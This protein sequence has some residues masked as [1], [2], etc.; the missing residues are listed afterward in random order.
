MQLWEQAD[1][2]KSP[3]AALNLGVMYSQGRY[4]GQAADQVSSSI[5]AFCDHLLVHLQTTPERLYQE[6]YNL[7]LTVYGLS[8]LSEVCRERAHQG[9]HSPC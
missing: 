5:N 8:V 7:Y 1:L 6:V 3:D 2:L 9:S 4:P